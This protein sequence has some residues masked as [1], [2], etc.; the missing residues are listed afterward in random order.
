MDHSGTGRNW[1]ADGCGGGT[2]RNGPR[3][4]FWWLSFF[5][6]LKKETNLNRADESGTWNPWRWIWGTWF[7]FSVFLWRR[8]RRILLEL[9][10]LWI[11]GRRPF[12]FF[13]SLILYDDTHQKEWWRHWT[14]SYVVAETFPNFE[15]WQKVWACPNW[16]SYFCSLPPLYVF[17]SFS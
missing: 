13:L 14:K 15:W 6:Y 2:V 17:I 16:G 1:G 7:F 10:L 5:Y 3:F 9:L 8:K 12:F 11:D 4:L